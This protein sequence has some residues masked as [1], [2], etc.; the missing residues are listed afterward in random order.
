MT[1][2]KAAIDIMNVFQPGQ[3][4]VALS[5][6]RSL[7]GLV[8]LSKI[9]NNGIGNDKE[10]IDYA[11]NKASENEL[12]QVYQKENKEFILNF[13]KQCFDWSDLAQQWRNYQFEYAH[14]KINEQSK[15]AIEKAGVVWN[16]VDPA[17]K[18]MR[19][20]DKLFRAE[21]I[22]FRY[23]SQRINA[24]YD[25]FF[26]FFVQL[27][28]DLLYKI[29]EVQNKKRT[30]Q[31]YES[32]TDIEEIQTKSILNLMRSKLLAEA[33]IEN[34]NL[35]KTIFDNEN[36]KNYKQEKLKIVKQDFETQN[37]T[38]I[39]EEP[40]VIPTKKEKKETKEPTINVTYTLWTELK[41]LEKVAAARKL[42][43]GTIQG[44]IAK[45]IALDKIKIEEVMPTDKIKILAQE[46]VN[47]DGESLNPIKEKLGDDFSWDE[48][49]MYRASLEN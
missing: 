26:P 18:F 27:S 11:N 35:S 36:I 21:V 33:V 12:E 32:L 6:L 44:H 7:D 49:K 9:Q 45:L 47:F 24:A 29:F 4:Y 10:V 39:A 8:L 19:Q 37:K 13:L 38:L 42:T 23:I 3:A 34:K 15:W 41:S 1:F 14:D 46:F 28:Y 22:D 31:Q 25:Y 48:L 2:D 16:L 5:R 30:K 43:V 20:L 40:K 17:T